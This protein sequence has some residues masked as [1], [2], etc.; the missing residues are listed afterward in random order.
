MLTT[1]RIRQLIGKTFI[2][3]NAPWQLIDV[4]PAENRIVLQ[5][6]GKAGRQLQTNQYGEAKR[7]V[8]EILCLPISEQEAPD[9]YSEALLQLL[10]GI[11]KAD[12]KRS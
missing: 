2:Y 7:Q 12:N 3:Q 4:L 1:D 10:A 6:L 5:C 9:N 8:P 11:Q